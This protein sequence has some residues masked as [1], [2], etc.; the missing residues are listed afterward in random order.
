MR[1]RDL[2]LPPER[3]E[4]LPERTPTDDREVWRLLRELDAALGHPDQWV[5]FATG[6]G[7]R[8]IVSDPERTTMAVHVENG[9]RR[10]SFGFT[11]LSA[12][13]GTWMVEALRGRLPSEDSEPR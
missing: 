12:S 1:A 7:A 2:S 5:A 11:G 13:G 10:A 6:P 8:V 4:R 9:N 3:P